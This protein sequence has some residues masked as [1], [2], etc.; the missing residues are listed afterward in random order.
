MDTGFKL[1]EAKFFF[2]KLGKCDKTEDEYLY[3]FTA[4]LNSWRGIWDV[5]LYDFV[6]DYIPGL[7][8]SI[9]RSE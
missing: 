5:M 1:E 2:E 7:S 4:F 8:K 9:D 3:Y 6:S